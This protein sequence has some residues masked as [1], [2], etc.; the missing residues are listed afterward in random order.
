MTLLVDTSVVVKWFHEDGE[1]E[2]DEARALLRAHRDGR[3]QLLVLDLAAYELGN[4]L[5]RRLGLPALVVAQQ[6]RLLLTLCG[7]L[8]H[9]RPS[10]L[11]AAA[12]LGEQHGLTFYDSSWA[13]AAQALRCPL[14]SGDRLLLSAGLAI[15]ATEAAAAP[16]PGV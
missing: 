10:W 16:G 1:S 5:L 7:P 8:V 14:V 11:D 12:D 3:E 15:T 13:A 2:V 4:V 9:P 6:L